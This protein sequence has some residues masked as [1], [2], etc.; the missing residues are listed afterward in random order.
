MPSESRRR[1]DYAGR[2]ACDI[3]RASVDFG[4]L[5]A[6]GD[7]RLDRGHHFAAQFCQRVFGRRRRGV[8][9]VARNQAAR[10]KF[11]QARGQ[12]AR[13]NHRDVVAQFAEAARLA[14]ESPNDVRRPGAAQQ[15]QAARQ[16]ATRRWIDFAFAQRQ[17]HGWLLSGSQVT[18]G[19]PHFI[20]YTGLDGIQQ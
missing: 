11:A 5:V 13:G 12:H 9:Q 19:I 10:L 16:R 7:Q 1:R 20:S 4:Q 15:Q 2:F 14:R 18:R 8:E 17:A 6:D 3:A